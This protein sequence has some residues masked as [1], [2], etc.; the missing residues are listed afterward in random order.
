MIRRVGKGSASLEA[1]KFQCNVRSFWSYACWRRTSCQGWAWALWKVIRLG[2]QARAGAHGHKEL[3]AHFT[4]ATL[5]VRLKVEPSATAYHSHDPSTLKGTSLDR[6]QPRR[7]RNRALLYRRRLGHKAQ[8]CGR[9]PRPTH[10]DPPQLSRAHRKSQ[11]ALLVRT[12]WPL[13]K[14]LRNRA[15][16]VK[17]RSSSLMKKKSFMSNFTNLKGPSNVVREK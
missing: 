12:S 2:I 1:Q 13:L 14:G 17:S 4:G 5:L 16:R 8:C 6:T 9:A 10:S 11:T 7:E 15:R 3:S